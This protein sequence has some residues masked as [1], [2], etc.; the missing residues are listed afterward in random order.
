[1]LTQNKRPCF[2][3]AH[4]GSPSTRW[5]TIMGTTVDAA[6][7]DL[8]HKTK[9]LRQKAPSKLKD[10]W[11]LRF[12]LQMKARVQ[13]LTFFNPDINSNHQQQSA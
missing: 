13:E 10:K 8:W 7:R 5:E 4:L 6:H 2:A 9:I 1:M 3:S 11:A 12:R